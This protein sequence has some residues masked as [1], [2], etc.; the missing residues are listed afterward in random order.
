MD[1]EF[2]YYMETLWSVVDITYNVWQEAAVTGSQSEHYDF[3][4]LFD[5]VNAFCL[6][7]DVQAAFL[8]LIGSEVKWF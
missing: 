7:W 2:K 3:V 4:L 8:L 1:F 6:W 5:I